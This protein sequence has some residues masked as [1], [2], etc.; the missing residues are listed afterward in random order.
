MAAPA[1]RARLG[2]RGTE[3]VETSLA[4]DVFATYAHEPLLR[5][6]AGGRCWALPHTLLLPAGVAPLRLTVGR[7]P[8]RP[9]AG[10]A[11]G[12][13]LARLRADPRRFDGTLVALRALE[14][15]ATGW[16]GRVR[17][18][19][20]FAARASESLLDTSGLREREAQGGRLPPVGTGALA[21]DMGVV[22]LLQTADDRLVIQRRGPTLDWRAGLL[23]V[24]ASGSLEPGPDLRDA[25]LDRAALLRGAA[26]EL[27]EEVGVG[28]ED[29]LEM[30]FLGICRELARGGKPEVYVAARV[31][32]DAAAVAARQRGA[33]D[34][35]EGAGLRTVP[36]P[37]SGAALDDQL[38]ALL[39]EADPALLA[40]LL[41][42]GCRRGLA[43][44]ET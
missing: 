28:H 27:R 2:P 26:R 21:G 23:S 31:G 24:T 1:V 44:I 16:E 6:R 43:R 13:V 10:V 22:V 5:V 17:P 19:S 20:Y 35:H 41:L 3:L 7:R 18:V 38:A 8:H 11:L 29:G 4:V 14:R 12:P 30:S 34:A 42:D 37:A 25:V 36:V 40:A 15:T 33:R 39:A 9:G 32:L